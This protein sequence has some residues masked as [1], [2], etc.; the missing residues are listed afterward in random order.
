M[1]KDANT[2]DGPAKE[3]ERRLASISGH[4]EGYAGEAL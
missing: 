1:A 2:N 4:A 3:A